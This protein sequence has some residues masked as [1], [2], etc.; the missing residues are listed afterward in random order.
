MQY[1]A[2]TGGTS[3]RVMVRMGGDAPV[4]RVRQ[5]AERE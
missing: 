5:P 1:R 3:R 4:D 2:V